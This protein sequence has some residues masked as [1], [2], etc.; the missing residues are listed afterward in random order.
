MSGPE[1]TTEP[2]EVV[3]P[4][5]AQPPPP[6]PPPPPDP[7]PPQPPAPPADR[8]AP[9][10]TITA[11][12]PAETASV[13][14]AFS[15]RASEPATTFSCRVDGAAFAP[16]TSPASYESLPLGEHSFAVRA[17]DKAGNTGPATTATWRVVPP[18]DT[19]PPTTTLSASIDGT[20]ASFTFT[21]SEAGSTFSCA[22]D[23]SSFEACSSPRAYSRLAP[24]SHTFAV[25]ATDVA[26][27]TGPVATH[28]WSIAPPLPDLVITS[29]GRSGFTVTNVGAA[30]AGPF[31]VSVTFI[32]TF[33][34]SGLAPGQ[35][36]TRTWSTLCPRGRVLTAVADRGQ[37]V[38]ES[39]EGNNARS[40]TC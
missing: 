27:N 39:N 28:T 11:R 26:G 6:P 3:S 15:F 25:R 5:A 10:V 32:G 20:S 13:A 2:A 29:L 31:V 1:P 4:T 33:T 9:T 37:A 18:P 22:L 7:P 8:T 30:P 23:G 16:C 36:A 35:S 40:F 21:S 12:P 24:G 38:A 14:A 19:S 17:R 34:F